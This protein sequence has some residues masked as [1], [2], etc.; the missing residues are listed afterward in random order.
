MK[1][2][3]CGKFLA[4]ASNDNFVDI[5]AAD[6]RYKHVGTCSGSSS[7]I[8]HIDWSEDSKYLQTN[9]GAAERL[10]HKMP[11][12]K[13][14]TNKEE[15]ANIRWC[16]FTGVLGAEVNGI[17]EKYTDTNDINASDANYS[18]EVIVTGDDFGLVKLFKF[19]SLKK[20]AKFRKYIGH[21][22]HVTN[23]RFSHDRNRVISTGGADHAVFQWRFLPDGSTDSSDLP[24]PQS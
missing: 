22:A 24:D 11:S 4:V 12:G 2:S 3:P 5:Y 17:W 8:T 6:Q 16:T 23:V 13:Q 9:S 19:P 21:S 1:Y 10:I 15:K 7:F 18:S 14:V 20:G